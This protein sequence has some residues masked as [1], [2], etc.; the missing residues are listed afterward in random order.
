MDNTL[1][2]EMEVEKEKKRQEMQEGEKKGEGGAGKE[3]KMGGGNY[4]IS[5][6][7]DILPIKNLFCVFGVNRV[8]YLFLL[9]HFLSF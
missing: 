5:P 9:C 8:P 4:D 6:I 3:D 7:L 2:A 1:S